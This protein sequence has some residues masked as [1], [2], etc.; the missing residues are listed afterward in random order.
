MTIVAVGQF[1]LSLV[2]VFSVEGDILDARQV[3]IAAV[4]QVEFAQH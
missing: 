1:E 4:G 2:K 3:K